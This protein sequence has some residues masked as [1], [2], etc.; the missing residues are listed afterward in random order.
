VVDGFV[1]SFPDHYTAPTAA[2]L[3]TFRDAVPGQVCGTPVEEAAAALAPVGYTVEELRD[4]GDPA[5]PDLR[6]LRPASGTAAAEPWGLYVLDCR[7]L[8]GAVIEVPHPIADA[9]TEDVGVAAFR[10]A[11]AAALLVAGTR[12]EAMDPAHTSRSVFETVHRALVAPRRLMVQVHGFGASGHE[13]VGDVV[14]SSGTRPTA[15]TRAVRDRLQ[16]SGFRV[17]LYHSGD[18]CTDLGGTTNVQGRTA[19]PVAEFLHLELSCRTRT[20]NQDAL[21][22]AV[23]GHGGRA[24]STQGL[25]PSCSGS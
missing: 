4:T 11:S 25:E 5:A 1:A 10:E 6:V 7:R 12:R 8:D 16:A 20:L 9:H 2:V 15:T 13:G 23:F 14:L 18:E 3:R 22:R 17:C 24:A 21:V 19:R